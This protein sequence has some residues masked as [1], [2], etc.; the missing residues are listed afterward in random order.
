MQNDYASKQKKN[1]RRNMWSHALNS[2]SSGNRLTHLEWLQI[3]LSK[4]LLGNKLTR[5]WSLI[6][7]VSKQKEFVLSGLDLIKYT[8]IAKSAKWQKIDIV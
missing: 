6:E 1:R 2:Y 3:I 7:C 4:W 8:L 5:N